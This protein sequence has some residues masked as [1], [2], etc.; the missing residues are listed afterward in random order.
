LRIRKIP[1]KTGLFL[2]P[3]A[4]RPAPRD[5]PK[6][7]FKKNSKKMLTTPLSFAILSPHTVTTEHN[8]TNKMRTKTLLLS[9]A[10]LLAAGIVSSQA[11]AVYSQN[12]VGYAS[13]PTVNAGSYYALACPFAIGASN[14]LN[15]VFGSTLS[16]YSQVLTWSV[17]SQGY[18]ITL[19]DPDDPNGIGDYTDV[20]YQSDDSTVVSEIPTVPPGQGFFLLPYAKVTNT[21]AG[22]IPINT[23]ATNNTKLANAGS[24]YMVGSAV[25]YSGVITNGGGTGMGINLNGLAQ[26]TQIL[27]WNVGSQ[28]YTITLYDPDDPNGIGDYADQ[29]YQSD[30]ATVAPAPTITVGQGFFILPYGSYTWTQVLPGN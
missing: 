16:Q 17:A 4:P 3:D 14:G 22:V 21:F 25:P 7:T 23:G 9:A 6:K 20:W 24:Y 15:E 8:T 18:T 28:G 30:D 10:A 5:P 12:V 19:Y 27:T 29:W 1:C 2:A 13:V 11:Q 26:Y